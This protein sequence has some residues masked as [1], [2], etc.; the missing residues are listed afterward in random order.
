M[1]RLRLLIFCLSVFLVPRLAWAQRVLV[2]RPPPDDRALV[3]AFGRLCAELEIERFEVVVVDASQLEPGRAALEG[4][5]RERD[6]LA[7]ISFERTPGSTTAELWVVDRVTGKTTLRRL[8]LEPSREGPTLLAVRAV[9][10]LRTSL[11]ELPP[12]ERPPKDVVDADPRPPP[13]AV[14]EFSH[15]Q[16]RVR[17]SVGALGLF[18]PD[19]GMSVG[20]AVEASARVTSFLALGVQLTGPLFGAS[21][22]ASAGSARIRRELFLGE[23][24]LFVSSRSGRGLWEWG[25]VLGLGAHH[26][27]ATGEVQPPLVAETVDSWSFA[28]AANLRARYYFTRSLALTAD[29]GG[30]ALAVAPVVA[31]DT[32]Q[33]PRLGIHALGSLAL[34]AAF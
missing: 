3:E 23:A 30:L 1:T 26:L 8:S 11:A 31:V 21:F 7:A 34:T 24:Q 15:P 4:A 27:E 28:F 16:P 29:L 25:P 22:D 17:A 10:L 9:D 5:A 12:G 13:P 18:H 33:T 19:I 2:V 32:E 6:V 14:H 20:A